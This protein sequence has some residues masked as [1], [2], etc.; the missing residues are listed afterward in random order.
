MS[1]S[2]AVI[3]SEQPCL[4]STLLTP[5]GKGTKKCVPNIAYLELSWLDYRIQ[6][7]LQFCGTKKQ[8]NLNFGTWNVRTLMDPVAHVLPERR[9]ALVARE[10]G[11]WKL[12]IIALSETRFAGDGQLTEIGG[13]YTFFWKGKAQS[14]PRI[15][16]VGF[17]IRTALMK[18]LH[19]QP[20]GI[21]ERLMTMRLSLSKNYFATVI[22]AYAP[23]LDADPD[24][25]ENFYA[26]LY[27]VLCSIPRT[28]KVVLLG[29]FNARVG[30]DSSLWKGVLGPYGTGT[31][32]ENG[33]MLLS[34]CAEHGLTITNTLFKQKKHFRTSWQHPRSKHWYLIDYV[35]VRSCDRKDVLC[36]K[37]VV[38]A[39]DCWTDHRLIASR[40]ALVFSSRPRAAIRAVRRKFDVSKLKDPEVLASFQA[41][42]DQGL[43]ASEAITNH[44]PGG[45]LSMWNDMKSAILKSCNAQLGLPVKK[46]QDWFDDNDEAITNLVNTKRC[47]FQKWQADKT[48]ETKHTAFL[49]AK[50]NVQKA[51]REMKNQWWIE[52]AEEIQA[53]ADK[54][55]YGNFYQAT[56]R[57]YGPAS[58][59]TNPL[60]SSDGTSLLKSN[61]QIMNRWCEHFSELLNRPSHVDPHLFDGLTP[62]SP[63]LELD[64]PPTPSELMKATISMKNNKASGSDGIPAEAFKYGGVALDQALF[65]LFTAVWETRSLPQDMRDA[66]IISIF[67]KG[68]RSQCGNYRGISLLSTAGK[69]LAKI[70]QARLSVIA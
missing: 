51:T 8:K 1:P 28:D 60:L 67:K 3:A 34:K 26:S 43:P 59:G 10:L 7:V 66:T 70:L 4:G 49:T 35:I 30:T 6:H 17:A 48:S 21:S 38:A 47:S 52:R 14:E 12:D 36:T 58:H 20:I 19:E 22:S 42:L 50:A 53:L 40:M 65:T 18:H 61:C 29:D 68:D 39:D 24:D 54:H 2:A 69:I 33:L 63:V 37:A 46:H 31:M 27:K 45:T 55:D 9:T 13:G 41:D 25:K 62:R 56:R 44:T 57:L 16:G 11:H 5:H 23:T 32:N 64:D 15:H